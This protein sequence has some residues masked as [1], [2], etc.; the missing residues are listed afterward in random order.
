[1]FEPLTYEPQDPHPDVDESDLRAEYGLVRAYFKAR[2]EQFADVQRRLE[3][4]RMAD[5]YDVYLSRLVRRTL[6]AFGTGVIVT[7]VFTLGLLSL[8][9]FR[10]PVSF[11]GS[12]ATRYLVLDVPPGT[13]EYVLAPL[14]ALDVGLLVGFVVA[15][16]Y[17]VAPI[18]RIAEREREITRSLPHATVYMY[19]LSRGGLELTRIFDDLAAAR[20]TYGVVSD[21]VR[22]IIQDVRSFDLDFEA[23]LERAQRETPC[24]EFAGFLDDLSGV[25]STGSLEAFFERKAQRHLEASRRA[26]RETLETLSILAEVYIVLVFAT[27]LFL[28]VILITLG[29]TGGDALVQTYRVTYVGVPVGIVLT[30]VGIAAFTE[31]YEHPTDDAPPSRPEP[32]TRRLRRHPTTQDSTAT[33]SPVAGRTSGT[34]SGG[35]RSS[36]TRSRIASS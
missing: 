28:L 12:A 25:I 18:V 3:R 20:S 36:S 4:A 17:W 6:A 19:A 10:I 8:A 7:L 16:G 31:T 34:C 9:P 13:T 33:G 30:L 26:Q 15:V 32:V 11:R 35:S 23:A 5:P 2:P 1:M 22:L 14:A 29:L 21:E 24:S 27:P